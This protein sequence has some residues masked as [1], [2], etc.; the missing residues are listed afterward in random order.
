MTITDRTDRT[1]RADAFA[2]VRTQ[3]RTMPTSMRA[4]A[5]AVL[6]EPAMAATTRAAELAGRAGV[7]PPRS[8]ASRSTSGSRTSPHS[9][10]A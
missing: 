7:S 2:L 10:A 8:P 6:D 3:F 1:D 9:S 4:I 5:D